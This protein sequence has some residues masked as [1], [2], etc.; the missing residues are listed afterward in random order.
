MPER[1]KT[2]HSQPAPDPLPLPRPEPRKR[3]SFDFRD[4]AL[5]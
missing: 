5:I 3:D 2:R 1:K 4:W